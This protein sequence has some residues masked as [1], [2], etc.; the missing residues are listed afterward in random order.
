[1]RPIHADA[2][3]VSAAQ[4][5]VGH[6]VAYLNATPEQGNEQLST[7]PK[8]RLERLREENGEPLRRSRARL[9]WHSAAVRGRA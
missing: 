5:S 9:T 6:Y 8:F 7:W 3:S 2:G 1:M 4:G